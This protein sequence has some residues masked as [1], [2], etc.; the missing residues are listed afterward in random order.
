MDKKVVLIYL[1]HPYL[2]QPDAQAPL[3][4][5]YL[6]AVLEQNKIAVEVK[7]YSCLLT[8]QAIEDLPEADLYGVTITSLELPQANRFA[9]LIKEKFPKSKVVFGGPGTVSKE[10]VDWTFV[11]SICIGDGEEEI[12]KIVK[13][14]ETKSLK[15]E[16]IG[17][18]MDNLD[19]L[20]F[21]A[22]H[23]LHGKQGGNIF[24]YN[25][26][27]RTGDTTI[28]TSSRGCP[29]HCSF[30]GSPYFTDQRGG[31]RFRGVDNIIQ[32]LK[33]IRSEFGIEQIRFSDDM[34][35]ANK[36]RCLSLCSAIKELDIIYR[37]SIRVKP[38]DKETAQALF[39]SGC[40][41]VSFG[42]ESF[43]NNVLKVLNKG[44]TSEDN[45]KA[46]EIC[47]EV[48]LKTRILFM[49]RTPGQTS[50]TV[51]TNIEWLSK[52]PYDIIACTSFVPLPGSDI[53]NNPDKYNIEILTKNLDLYNF[54]FFGSGGENQ[55]Q[56]IIKIKDRPLDEFN[57][58]T[59]E[60]RDFLKS[61]GKVNLG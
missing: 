27:Y 17:C 43:D 31:V 46:L 12:L 55:L 9:C 19:I 22:R 20:P 53:W 60:F 16:Y 41:E 33:D 61:T 28:V 18:G 58:E 56:N 29:F 40:K 1:P 13:D 10:L 8:Y 23:L 50:K 38:F 35:T 26:T 2:K 49:I 37:V 7:N 42:V 45:A 24:A 44:V 6:A 54:Y 32:E 34:F 5:L 3:G 14:V 4:L 52:V 47:N 25:K 15:R 21:P 36:K 11:D 59:Q 30:C 51:P 48:G 39:D 57:N